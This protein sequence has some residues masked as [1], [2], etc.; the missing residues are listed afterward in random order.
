MKKIALSI[1]LSLTSIIGCNDD[2]CIITYSIYGS[3]EVTE[4]IDEGITIQKKSTSDSVVIEFQTDGVLSGMSTYNSL[5]G[6]FQLFPN[7][8]IWIIHYGGTEKGDT[9]LGE[10]FAEIIPK[11]TFYKIFCDTTLSLYTSNRNSQINFKKYNRQ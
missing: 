4:I 2:D 3:W 7:D 1:V 10:K 6:R 5:T 9:E 11:L 8:S